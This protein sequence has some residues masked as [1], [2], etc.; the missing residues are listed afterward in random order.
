MKIL[1]TVCARKG[2]KGLK[3]KNISDFLGYPICY[4]TL[5]AY[6]LFKKHNQDCVCKL[7]LNTD[8]NELVE[9]FNKTSIEFVHIQRTEELAGDRVGKIDV[10]KDTF[11]KMQEDFDYIIDLDLTSPLRTAVDIRGVLQKL[12][13]DEKADVA[14]SMTNSRRSP[15]FNQVKQYEDGYFKPVQNTGALTRQE[16]PAVYDMNA[17]IYAYRPNFLKNAGKIFESKALGYEMKDTAILDIDN[18]DDKEFMEI[19]A[20]HFYTKYDEYREIKD[21]I[22]LLL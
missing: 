15:Y 7:A 9:Q 11:I 1:F 3:N 17:S 4:Y 19:I 6:N 18:P 12:L 16:V 5:S 14:F 2:S 22:N 8:S 21:G 20:E 10:I 13:D